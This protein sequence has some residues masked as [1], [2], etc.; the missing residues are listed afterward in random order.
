M[1]LVPEFTHSYLLLYTEI[2][3]AHLISAP[4]LAS[5]Q[6]GKF[7]VFAHLHFKY[8]QLLD[9]LPSL[10]LLQTQMIFS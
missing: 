9:S 2:A 10:G 6:L 8:Y 7:P 1:S 5:C 4:K 3:A